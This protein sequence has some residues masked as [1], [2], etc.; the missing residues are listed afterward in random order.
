MIDIAEILRSALSPYL[1]N[2]YHCNSLRSFRTR[3]SHVS[4]VRT[5]S[6]SSSSHLQPLFDTGPN[7]EN[8]RI[9]QLGLF[10]PDVTCLVLFWFVGWGGEAKDLPEPPAWDSVDGLHTATLKEVSMIPLALELESSV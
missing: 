7:A 2:H 4:D 5:A 10:T 6:A 9:T 8:T 1:A 3:G